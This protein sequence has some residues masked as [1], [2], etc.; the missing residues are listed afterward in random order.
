M[1]GLRIVAWTLGGLLVAVAAFLIATIRVVEPKATTPSAP[2]GDVPT[3]AVAAAPENAPPLIVPVA[4]I[5]FAAIRSNWGEAREEG[6]R[7]HE[8]LDIMAPGGTPVIAA[9][10]GVVEKLFQS[11]AGG[12][13]LYQR[14]ADGRWIFYY[15]HLA[16]YAP[17]IA[18]G[19][20]V[21]AGQAVGYVG[22]T[23][24]AGL[25]NYHLHF[26]ISRM[27]PG[28]SWHQ[29]VPVDPYPLLAAGRAGG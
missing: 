13:T 5:S 24:N 8:G 19:R 9:A 3:V 28:E 2:E 25:G 16:A 18:E 23:G 11:D 15:A 17:G 27:G 12:I 21:R 7:V 1:K 14:S 29:G 4:G 22:D 26:G 20:G 10:D 6:A